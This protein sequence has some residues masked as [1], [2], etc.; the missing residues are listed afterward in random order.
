MSRI[1]D[2]LPVRAHREASSYGAKSIACVGEYC[3]NLDRAGIR[4]G[5]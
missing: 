2:T 5:T 4:S 3:R 1:I